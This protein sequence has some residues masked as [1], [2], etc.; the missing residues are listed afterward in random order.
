MIGKRPPH[1]RVVAAVLT[2]TVLALHIATPLAAQ[3]AGLVRYTEVLERRVRGRIALP[4]TVESRMSS[5]VATEVEGL[6]IAME[7]QVGDRV[8]VA[9]PL[10]RLRTIFVELELRAAQGRVDQTQAEIA[11]LEVA[12]NRRVIRAPFA[13]IV[14]LQR[15]EVGQ[16]IDEGGPV[17]EMIAL[18]ELEV[19]VEMPER[20]YD[21]I[22]R[23]VEASVRFAALPELEIEGRVTRVIP[24]AD[25]QS[26]SFPVKVVIPNPQGRVAVGMLA[27]VS[28]PAGQEYDAL[29]VAKDALVRQGGAEIVFRVNGDD[30]VE[31]VAIKSRQGVGAWIVVNGPLAAGDHVVVRGNE[32]LFP[33]QSVQSE[34]QEYPP[35]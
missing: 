5:V 17:V 7:V 25:A 15:T 10:A 32:R 24:R 16:W 12:L 20:Y 27:E 29:M 28:L 11:G 13:G 2:G 35:P 21:Q 31:P 1:L 23:G 14:V 9:Q 26:R 4:G 30:T 33:G 19:R 8:E 22:R 6:V 3:P 18:G 34:R